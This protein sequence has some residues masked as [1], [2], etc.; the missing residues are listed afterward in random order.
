MKRSVWATVAVVPMFAA[1]AVL[2][3][4]AP[5]AKPT[6]PKVCMNCH[7]P[8]ANTVSGYFDS[9]AFKT[10]SVQL[11]L[12]GTTEIVRFD[13]KTVKVIDAGDAKPVE[14]LREVKKGHEAQVAFAERDGQKWATE[15]RFKG[16]IKIA[17]DKLADYAFVRDVVDKGPAA[18]KVVLIDSRPLPRFQQGTIPGA[19]NLPYPSWDKFVNLLPADKATTIV[20]FCQ[21]PTCQMSPSSLRKAEA[22]GYTAAKVYQAGVPEWQTKDYLLTNPRFV[23]E[24]YLDKD[25]PAVIV[26]ARNVDSSTGGHIKGAVALPPAAA[27][28]LGAKDLPDPKLAAPFIVFDGRGGAE[29]VAVARALIKA[30]QTNVQ[31]VDGGLIGWQAAGFPIEAGVPAATRIA[32]APKPRPGSVPADEFVKLAQN[33]PADVL[34]LD[35]RNADEANAGMIKGA[36]LI[37]DEELAAR[38]KELPKDKRIVTHC[39]S[40]VRAEMAYHKLK[41]AGYKAGF[42]NADIEIAKDGSI[43]VTPKG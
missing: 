12:D 3:Q 35:V 13:P 32:Y 16:P 38:I 8:A 2:A 6:M 22:L 27:A 10:T 30:G 41:D 26:D 17:K 31:V 33:T 43:K 18:S 19:I 14:H 34:I 40:R 37:P 4:T 23:K 29:S 21:G 15:I 24:A 1:G 42:L 7:K 9:V 5:A 11:G 25:I 36:I 28:K 39:A 20:F